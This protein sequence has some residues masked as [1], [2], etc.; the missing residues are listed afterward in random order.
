MEK[1]E[2]VEKKKK[3]IKDK[4]FIS[5]KNFLGIEKLGKGTYGSVYKAQKRDTNEFY[6]IKKIKL[7]VDTEGIP[8][9]A[10][11]EIAIL[12]KLKHPNIV[13][14][15]DLAISD[16]KIELCLEFC[17]FDLRK[18]MDHYKDNSKI[19]NLVTIKSIMFQILKAVDHLHSRKILH[20]DLKPQNILICDQTLITKIA[21]FG[22]SRVYAIPIRPYT[23]E[24]LTLWYRAPELML[25]LNQYSTGL[26]MWSVGCI[27]AE[28]IIKKPLFAGDSEIDQL[29][30]IFR[31]FGT[32]NDNTL[33]GYKYFPDY[34]PNFPLWE[35][36]GL[37]KIIMER[38]DVKIDAIAFDLMEKML[39][40]D[41]CKRIT[42]KEALTHV[43]KNNIFF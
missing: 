15:Q 14:I 17:P 13:R 11:R 31:V 21:D 20:R 4:I 29:Y 6:A 10:L 33:P 35:E 30:K 24:V 3:N 39:V 40:I 5:G 22:L 43:R 1:K 28:L 37:S 26:D 7:D 25:G 2:K 42:A 18:Y 41:P 38:M 27:F 32:P 8:S 23:K 12:K 16:K 34:N 19:Y 9:T 36:V